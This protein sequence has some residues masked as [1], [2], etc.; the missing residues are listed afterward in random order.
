MGGVLPADR[1]D[2]GYERRG[3]R[4]LVGSQWLVAIPLLLAALS[5]ADARPNAAAAG[6]GSDLVEMVRLAALGDT[7]AHS[8]APTALEAAR[9]V[10]VDGAGNYWIGGINSFKIFSPDATYLGEVG[11]AG[12]GPGE[13]ASYPGPAFSDN[14]GNV[15]VIDSRTARETVFNSDRELVATYPLESVVHAAAAIGDAGRRVFS[16]AMHQPARAGLPLHIYSGPDFERSFGADSGQAIIRDFDLQRVLGSDGRGR[17]CAAERYNYVVTCWDE[18][19]NAL[20]RTEGPVLNDPPVEPGIISMDRGLPSVVA[21][22]RLL[23]DGRIAVLRHEKSED[24]RSHVDEA[25]GS[26]GV[27]GIKVLRADRIYDAFIDV[28]DPG[29]GSI[30]STSR[31][32]VPLVAFVGKDLAW[33]LTYTEAGVPLVSIWRVTI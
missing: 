16:A 21:D 22:L 17:V 8:T 5:C 29:T 25:I 19:G 9:Y 6:D 31:I 14:D 13:F 30:V 26:N 10:A 3:V 20:L 12:E 24:W 1:A 2:L 28:I 23:Q 33:Q 27:I 15:H 18:E 4:I 32:E 7:S 11:R